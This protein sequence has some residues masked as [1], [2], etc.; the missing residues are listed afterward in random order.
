MRNTSFQLKC[1]FW[2]HFDWIL[3]IFNEK[4][5]VLIK[6]KE[7]F[8]FNFKIQNVFSD[9]I[10]I[11]CYLKTLKFHIFFCITAKFLAQIVIFLSNIYR[12]I[13]ENKI[14]FSSLL[15]IF[16]KNLKTFQLLISNK[17]LYKRIF[18][19]AKKWITS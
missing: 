4:S 1:F 3:T 2:T 6:N 19:W 12:I 11:K 5:K 10:Y 16:S 14:Y 9:V 8:N 17:Y 13:T 18:L 15:S 7:Y